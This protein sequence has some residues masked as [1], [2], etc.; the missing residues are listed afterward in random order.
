MSTKVITGIVRADHV[1]LF[2]PHSPIGS[3]YSLTIIIP[4]SDTVTIDKIRSAINDAAKS[5]IPTWIGSTPSFF[6]LPLQDGDLERPGNSFYSNSYYINC[7]SSE[8]PAIVDRNRLPIR[9]PEKI[10]SGCYIRVSVAFR[11]FN[12]HHICGVIAV[13][14]NIQFFKDGDPIVFVG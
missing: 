1:H 2:D 13:L 14:G 8:P 11:P 6:R 10:Y 3:R 4:K 5:G 12:G 7:Y 9:N